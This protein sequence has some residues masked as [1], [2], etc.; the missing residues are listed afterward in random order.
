MACNFRVRFFP[1]IPLNLVLLGRGA[2]AIS[3]RARHSDQLRRLERK[4]HS[5]FGVSSAEIAAVAET[6]VV[7]EHG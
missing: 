1:G 6:A 4:G 2:E 7:G 5:S 3:S